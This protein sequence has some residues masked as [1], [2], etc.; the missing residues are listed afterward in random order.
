M[1]VILFFVVFGLVS[2]EPEDAYCCKPSQG[3]M[4]DIENRCVDVQKNITTATKL[5]C[6]NVYH[7]NQSEFNFLVTN[8]GRLILLFG[9][10]PQVEADQ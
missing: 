2:C 8:D 5:S 9:N 6:D 4:A 10:E 3:V 1:K 7:F